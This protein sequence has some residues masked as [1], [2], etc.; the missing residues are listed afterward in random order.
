MNHEKQEMLNRVY[1]M[2]E[3]ERTSAEIRMQTLKA[4]EHDYLKTIE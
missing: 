1:K 2:Y 3:T 4:I